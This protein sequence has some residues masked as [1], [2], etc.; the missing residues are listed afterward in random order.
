MRNI[1]LLVFPVKDI[2]K[3]KIFYSK[4][5]GTEPYADSPY[6]V[7]YRIGDLEVGLDPNSSDGPISYTDTDDIKVSL[8]E[9]ISVGGEVVQQPHD[10]GGGLM[11]AQLKDGNGNTVGLRS[12]G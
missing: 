3:A 11:I 2:E 4:F 10:V 1:K 7:G 12:G 6:Y 8:D 9:M 5:L